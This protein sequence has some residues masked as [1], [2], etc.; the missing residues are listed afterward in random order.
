[1]V[2]KTAK[3]TIFS[4]NW[5]MFICFLS[6][7]VPRILLNTALTVRSI[8][9]NR[10]RHCPVKHNV[11]FSIHKHKNIYIYSCALVTLLIFNYI[12]YLIFI[13]IFLICFICQF[14]IVC[15]CRWLEECCEKQKIN[16][17]HD[18]SRNVKTKMSQYPC[19]VQ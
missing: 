2:G 16:I 11:H 6:R 18:I 3:S 14:T 13:F 17:L 7:D 8:L 4:V 19:Y 12:H 10:L 5:S 15:I 9:R 1:M